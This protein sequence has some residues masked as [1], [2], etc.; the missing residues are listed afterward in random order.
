MV[1]YSTSLLKRFNVALSLM[2]C[3]SDIFQVTDS[4]VW[5]VVIN[6]LHHRACCL[7]FQSKFAI[8]IILFANK[9]DS[10]IVMVVF[11]IS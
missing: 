1:V 10:A 2:I 3:L 5:V 6:Y 11:F 8:A 7:I 9:S 4:M